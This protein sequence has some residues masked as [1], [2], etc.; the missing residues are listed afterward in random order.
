VACTYLASER[1][2]YYNEVMYRSTTASLRSSIYQHVKE[3]G[4][5]YHAYKEGSESITTT[6]CT[7]LLCS[8]HAN[9]SALEYMLPNDEVSL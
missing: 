5:T 3:Y 8:S 4:R 6:R 7:A 1:L 2:F 9:D